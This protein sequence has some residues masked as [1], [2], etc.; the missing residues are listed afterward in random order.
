MASLS[1]LS[2]RSKDGAVTLS[3]LSIGTKDSV[4]LDA[5]LEVMIWRRHYGH[6]HRDQRMSDR[7]NAVFELEG[8][9][10]SRPPP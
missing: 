2:E 7:V 6:S 8:Q 10:H 4:P 9:C 1:S 5:L 3:A